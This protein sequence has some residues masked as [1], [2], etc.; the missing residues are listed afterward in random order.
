[1]LILIMSILSYSSPFYENALTIFKSANATSSSSSCPPCAI[2]RIDDI[3][4]NHVSSSIAVMNLFLAE[5]EPLTL[6]IVMNHIGKNPDLMEKI[7]EGTRK[8]LF[9]LAL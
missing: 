4:D 7:L 8:G 3:S 2:F 6:G 5:N 1:M 9:E